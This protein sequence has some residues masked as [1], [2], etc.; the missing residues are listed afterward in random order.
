MTRNS[1]PQLDAVYEKFKQSTDE[2]AR[3]ELA[4]D[5]QRKVITDANS[6]PVVWYS[7]IV[8]HVTNMKGWK[9]IPS[10]FANQDLADIWLE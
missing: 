4:K 7:R 1:N 10:H 3:L 5:M 8:A 6:I 9:I 2:A